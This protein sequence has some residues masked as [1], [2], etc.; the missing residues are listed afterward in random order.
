MDLESVKKGVERFLEC[1]LPSIPNDRVSDRDKDADKRG[2]CL[3]KKVS[4]IF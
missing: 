4:Y 3:G 1:V 2:V